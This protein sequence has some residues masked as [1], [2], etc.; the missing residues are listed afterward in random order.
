MKTVKLISMVL[1]IAALPF[2]ITPSVWAGGGAGGLLG[3]CVVTNPGGGAIA[4]KGTMAV[5]YTPAVYD[6][7]ISGYSTQRG[8]QTAS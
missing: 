4:I 7:E 8:C 1:A 6:G 3:C 2:L 5:V